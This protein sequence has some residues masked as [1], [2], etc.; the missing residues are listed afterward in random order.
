MPPC[1][2]Q[3]QAGA[4][5]SGG[6][7]RSLPPP[8]CARHRMCARVTA[9]R[10]RERAQVPALAGAV[11]G[12]RS[13]RARPRTS[14]PAPA[15]AAAHPASSP[16]AA[17]PPLAPA[18]PVLPAAAASAPRCLAAR[19]CAPALPRRGGLLWRG[20]GV[21]ARARP[22]PDVLSPRVPPVLVRRLLGGGGA[23]CLRR[24]AVPAL[25]AFPALGPLLPGLRCS[26]PALPVSPSCSP[27]LADRSPRSR[28][29]SP[30]PQETAPLVLVLVPASALPLPPA[31]ALLLP[32]LAARSPRSR[33][34]SPAPRPSCRGCSLRWT[35]AKTRTCR[36]FS[37]G[38][39]RG[40][41]WAQ[42]RD[43]L[44]PTGTC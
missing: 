23:P 8:R 41:R 40:I 33:S 15:C 26:F 43:H 39:P 17:A 1:G 5:R 38:T 12:A 37:T 24:W 10:A 27:P 9:T 19:A 30:A 35:P 28:S 44:R 36:R 22:A 18:R 42:R 14:P 16:A 20:R 31:L 7:S 13:M 32:A 29:R 34:R 6:Q 21:S 25:A 4:P 11:A 3:G 2:H